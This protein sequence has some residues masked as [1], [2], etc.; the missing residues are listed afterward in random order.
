MPALFSMRETINGLYEAEV[1]HRRGPWRLR[2][3]RDGDAQ[4]GQ[5]VQQQ[6][7]A[8]ADRKHTPGRGRGALLCIIQ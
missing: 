2:G 8:G 5:L 7:A 3:C 4:M 1:I 6:A